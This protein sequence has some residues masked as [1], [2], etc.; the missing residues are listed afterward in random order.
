MSRARMMVLEKVLD[1]VYSIDSTTTYVEQAYK[2][3]SMSI[4]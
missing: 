4:D 2:D 3:T 1:E